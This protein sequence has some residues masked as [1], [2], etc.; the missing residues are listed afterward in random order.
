MII[1]K[2][3]Q[4]HCIC[5]PIFTYGRNGLGN[6]P[7][8]HE[9]VGIRDEAESA[10]NRLNKGGSPHTT[11]LVRR[12]GSR[13]NVGFS[14]VS[15]NSYAHFTSPITFNHS[16]PMV[17]EGTVMGNVDGRLDIDRLVEIYESAKT[18]V[19]PPRPLQA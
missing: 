14:A 15:N 3:Y 9:H 17:V 12:A 7:H 5:V 2:T 6:K 1:V 10:T 16:C 8:A 13:R 19:L 18:F 4:L 11:I